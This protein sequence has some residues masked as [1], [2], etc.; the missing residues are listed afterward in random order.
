[1]DT[2]T[3]PIEFPECNIADVNETIDKETI[4]S[5]YDFNGAIIELCQTKRGE[6][7]K[8]ATPS[9]VVDQ[10]AILG[11]GDPQ[12][13]RSVIVGRACRRHLAPGHGPS[14]ASAFQ[15]AQK[16]FQPVV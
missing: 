1:M 10:Q 4:L 13:W 6:H 2:V 15:G 14:A 16:C 5:H 7:I 11:D 12:R 3:N 9:E 8:G